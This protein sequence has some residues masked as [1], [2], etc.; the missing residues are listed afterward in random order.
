V[1]TV[2]YGNKRTSLRKQ[3]CLASLLLFICWLSLISLVVAQAPLESPKIQGE[4]LSGKRVELPEAVSG[5]VAVLV[6]GFSRASKAPTTTWGTKIFEG[7][8]SQPEFAIYQLPVLQEV[9]RLLH[10]MIISGMQKNVPEKLHDHFV[11]LLQKEAELKKLVSYKEPDD[12]YLV[13]LD[14]AG[15][16]VYQIH[17]PLNDTNYA[18]LRDKLES[19][20][21]AG[22]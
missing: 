9:P 16:I 21:K 17:G 4:S 15:K 11:P 3:R 1:C 20:L 19:L 6:F 14:R 2:D 13:V 22:K 5:K 8:A 10:G 12:A 18:G 7:F